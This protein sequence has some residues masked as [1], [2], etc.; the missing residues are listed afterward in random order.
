M[1][2]PVIGWIIGGYVLYNTGVVISA[3]ATGLAVPGS[4]VFLFL[5]LFPFALLE[6]GAYS[7]ALTQSYFIAAGIYRRNIRPQLRGLALVIII[8]A[9]VLLLAAFIEASYLSRPV[10]AS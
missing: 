10:S 3:A 4:L 9:A 5:F 2:I 6:F 7:A 1:L 8:I